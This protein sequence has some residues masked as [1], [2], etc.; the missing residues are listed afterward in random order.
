MLYCDGPRT[1]PIIDRPCIPGILSA[2]RLLRR[3]QT[4]QGTTFVDKAIFS[5]ASATSY[6]VSLLSYA[7]H[8][9]CSVSD[10]FP[11][12]MKSDEEDTFLTKVLTM[13]LY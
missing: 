9:L 12:Q 13:I 10:P 6:A 8:R 3:R 2:A 4:L 1:R 11:F 5:V 7:Y